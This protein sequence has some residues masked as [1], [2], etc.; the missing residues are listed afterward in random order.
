MEVYRVQE[1]KMLESCEGVKRLREY[2]L[3][4]SDRGTVTQQVWRFLRLK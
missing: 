3:P 2:E 1:V 4:A